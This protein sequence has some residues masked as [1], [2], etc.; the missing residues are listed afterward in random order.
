[1]RFNTFLSLSFFYF[2][3]ELRAELAA[4]IEKERELR[5]H[6]EKQLNEEQKIRRKFTSIQVCIHFEHI[7]T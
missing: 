5:D 1:M 3:A 6:A 2:T 4:Q 7:L